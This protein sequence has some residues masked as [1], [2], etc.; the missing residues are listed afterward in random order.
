MPE[1]YPKGFFILDKS[2]FT[3]N[4]FFQS[5]S[6]AEFRI[7]VYLLA[8]VLRVTKRERRY[9]NGGL[10][11]RL[12]SDS[13]LL[14]ANVSQRTIAD[15]CNVNRSTAYSALDRF[16]DAG[17]AITINRPKEEG[18]ETFHILGFEREIEGDRISLYLVDSIQVSAGE[19]LPVGARDLIEEA[20]QDPGRL[21]SAREKG[22]RKT[23][24]ERLFGLDGNK[25]VAG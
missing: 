11:A 12:Y 13:H 24:L 1:R 20:Y 18:G 8:S 10:V 3:D 4:Q 17:A 14:V 5:L 21:Y 19:K 15:R 7:M 25:V 22:T 2:W 23:L 9:R 6:H 16:N